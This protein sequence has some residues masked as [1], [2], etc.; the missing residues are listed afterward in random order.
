MLSKTQLNSI[1]STQLWAQKLVEECKTQFGQ[2]LPLNSNEIEFLDLLL[3]KGE[4]HPNLLTQDELL[5]AN[6]HSHPGLKWKILKI[7]GH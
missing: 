4:L 7:L 2:L 5:V 1:D 6:M 3:D